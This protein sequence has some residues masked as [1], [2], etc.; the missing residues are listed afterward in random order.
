VARKKNRRYSLAFQLMAVQFMKHCES[1]TELSRELGVDRSLLYRWRDKLAPADTWIEKEVRELKR[2]LADKSAGV[3]P[4]G[5]K[6]IQSASRRGSA[7][8]K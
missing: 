7:R 3:E 2:M 6:S 8:R 1:I 4:S 5:R